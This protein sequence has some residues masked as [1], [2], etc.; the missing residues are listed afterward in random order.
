MA[1]TNIKGF[2]KVL[3][4]LSREIQQIKGNSMQG[5]IE[6]AALIR[7]DMDKTPPVI[8][9]DTNHLRGSYYS[10][11]IYSGRRMGVIMGFTANYAMIVHERVEGA[12]W[13][14]GVVGVVRWSRPGS[15]PKFFEASIKR[16]KGNILAIIAKRAKV[17]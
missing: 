11:P 3:R 9:V 8:P 15:G 6:S 13:G 12:K 17:R 14:S 1:Y 7:R 2:D 5:L 10:Q 16:N 4:N